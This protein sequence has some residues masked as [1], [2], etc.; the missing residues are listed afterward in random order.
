M[1]ARTVQKWFK[2]FR[3]GNRSLDDEERTGRP[4]EVDADNL[5]PLIEEDPRLSTKE[6]ARQLNCNFSTV[7]RHLE[8]FGK[9]CRSGKWVPHKL[10]QANLSTQIGVCTS[11]LIWHDKEP[12]LDRL[13]TGNKKWVLYI[14]MAK[15]RQWLSENEDPVPTPRAGPHP[16]KVLFSVWWNCH[17]VLY[18]ELFDEGEYI[19]AKYY[20]TQLK[21]LK[22]AIHKKRPSLANRKG[23]I[24]L[25]DNAKPHTAKVTWS[26]LVW[27]G[28]D[29]LAHPPYSP[30]LAPS[31]Y[32][33]FRSM[34]HFLEGKTFDN[35]RDLKN[36]LE[37]FFD[38]KDPFFSSRYS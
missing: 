18:F 24:F 37:K 25:H 9:T 7:A 33:L 35:K 15:K 4:T 34:Q 5:L 32:H 29:L 6:L 17:G 3:E 30:D 8:K 23:V 22:A 14:N 27:F 31:D 16:Q 19:N 10:S 36:S 2:R 20:C 38:S 11:L 1:A 26:T 13:V 28:W 21:R 12:F